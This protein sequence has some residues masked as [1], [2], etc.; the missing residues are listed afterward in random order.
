VSFGEETLDAE[1]DYIFITKMSQCKLYILHYN[2]YFLRLLFG[3]ISRV[4]SIGV[5]MTIQRSPRHVPPFY[6]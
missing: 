5:N 1:V 6:F 4:I 3:I 2:M